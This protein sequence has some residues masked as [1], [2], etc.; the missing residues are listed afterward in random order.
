MDIKILDSWLRDFLET[1]ATPAE[2]SKY[3]SLCG[4]S[5]ERIEKINGD[6]VYDIEVTTNRVDSASV[7]G[8]AREASAILPRFGISAKLKPI[9][10][11]SKEYSF[12]KSV[13]YLAA[14]VDSKLCPRF[15]AVLIENVQIAESPEIIKKGLE[16][17]GIRPIN[18]IIDISNY[19][20]LE[21]GQPVHTFD[22]DKIMEGRMVLRESK[23]GEE[24][25]T[26]D[27]KKFKL[28]GGDIVIEDGGGRLIDLAGIMGGS[29]SKVEADTKNV[30]LFVQT[31][32]PV[33]IRKTSM[34]LAQ[35]S[36]AATIFEKGT[37]TELVSQGVLKAI[38][39]FKT[40][41]KGTVS[42]QILDIYPSPYKAMSAAINMDY[43]KERLGIDIS[44]KDITSYLTSLKFDCKWVG[45]LL[46]IKI[47][48]FRAKDIKGPEDILEEIARIYG[49]HNLPSLIMTGPIPVRSED[50]KFNFELNVKN[51]ISGFGGSEVYTLSLIPESDTDEKHLKLKNP[52]GPKTA[53]LRTSLMPSL[54]NALKEN[55]GTTDK[56][57]LYEIANIYLP[58]TGD[59][60]EERLI[61]AGIFNGYD[62]RSA[63]GIVEGILER[64]NI[65][66]TFKTEES[67]GFG[68]SKCAFIYSKGEV[69][70]KIGVVEESGQIYYEFSMQKLL[71]FSPKVIS[72]KPVPKYPAQ[73]EDLTLFLP[74][75]TRIGD[76][77]SAILRGNQ[78]I[79]TVK[80]KDVY[81]SSYTFRIAYQNKDKTLTDAE[82]KEIRDKIISSLKSK[83]GASVKG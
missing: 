52:L 49:Y 3:I 77:V 39:L 12:T 26:L 62:Y 69:L 76:V 5:V 36:M 6:C 56:F 74:E 40:L 31:Y 4:P 9:R 1:K 10:S 82:V 51:I 48:S 57:H 14:I 15:T 75:K 34:A 54:V 71:D 67:K 7:Y 23:R 21:L 38:E 42:K 16:A 28:P 25:E 83:F 78:L 72:F 79:K 59:L 22:Y 53:A 70:G 30:L 66:I 61:L 45:D 60:P 29:L 81:H 11:E 50:P 24:I 44:K 35:R 20:M 8:I 80:F 2:I 73:I 68:A 65:A 64:L 41:T 43:I 47:P 63:K 13:P 32:N 27:G 46:T 37:D 55:I 58:K 19:V 33:K 18:N 17:S